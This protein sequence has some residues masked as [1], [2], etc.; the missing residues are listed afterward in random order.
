MAHVCDLRP[1][2]DHDTSQAL[3]E[4][5]EILAIIR[6]LPDTNPANRIH[7]LASLIH[8]A[9]T[10]LTRAVGDAH[11]DGYSP[12]EIAILLGLG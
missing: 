10:D 9:D 8:Q 2:P 11:H 7:L 4:A 1:Y 12:I 3:D 5:I 6:E